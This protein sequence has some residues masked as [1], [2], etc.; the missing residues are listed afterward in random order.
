MLYL[1][2]Q[3]EAAN[4]RGLYGVQLFHNLGLFMEQLVSRGAISSAQAASIL[5]SPVNHQMPFPLQDRDNPSTGRDL[6]PI[7]IAVDTP[8]AKT[9]SAQRVTVPEKP[10]HPLDKPLL[11]SRLNRPATAQPPNRRD[12]RLGCG[13]EAQL[14]P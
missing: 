4:L 9:P 8:L 13:V 3:T 2:G 11:L 14:Q 7:P 5:Q 6:F 10:G 1:S 12:G